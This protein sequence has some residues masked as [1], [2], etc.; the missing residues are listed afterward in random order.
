MI[1]IQFLKRDNQI[2]EH[3]IQHD[4]PIRFNPHE[5]EGT[6]RVPPAPN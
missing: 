3:Y 4:Q 2:L 6:D 5:L 1:G